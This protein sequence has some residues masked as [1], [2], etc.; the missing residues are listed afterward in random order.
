MGVS[1]FGQVQADAFLGAAH[2]NSPFGKIWYVDVTNGS[3]GNS[4][5]APDEAY[6]TI[7]QA[8]TS[9]L[10]TRG[11]SV[12]IAPGTYSITA[13][14]SPKS[15]MTF[16]AAV[17]NQQVPTVTIQGNITNLLTLNVSGCRF[18]GLRFLSSGNTSANLA[19][20]SNTAS[21]D[22][23]TF[24]DCA[25]E[26]LVSNTTQ[27][28]GLRATGATTFPRG[29]VVRRC[30]FSRLGR[31]QLYVGVLGIPDAKI[32]D[33]SFVLW[34]NLSAGIAFSNTANSQVGTGYVIRNNEF[35]NSS[36]GVGIRFIGG[37]EGAHTAGIIRNN[38]FAYFAATTAFTQNSATR[39]FIN[40]YVGDTGTGGTLADV[41]N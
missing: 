8:I 33:N 21:I 18:V 32:E 17:V 13:A 25:F 36:D 34:S 16:R 29:L 39:S 12:S 6:A 19:N 20:V 15:N 30:R 5:E 22:G 26:G 31:S 10:A 28:V 9:A 37:T 2:D 3:D 11:D 35:L 41:G 1:R 4:G 40:N 24:E 23:A 14:L 7:A 38:F 27:G